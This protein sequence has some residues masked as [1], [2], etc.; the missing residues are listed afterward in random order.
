MKKLNT[1]DLDG[2]IL[3]TFL[4]ILESSSVSNAAEK[5][6]LSQSNVSH[7]L[8]KLRTILGDPL[9]VRSGQG[10]TP[11]EAALAL[12]APVRAAL[13][14]LN[15]LTDLRPFDPKS[16]KM[17][18]V[19]A[20]NDMQRDLIFPQL[21]REL[22]K[23]G[24]AAEFEF[25]PSGHPTVGMMRDAKCQLALTPMAPDG[26]D[27][28]Q[29]SLFSGK[30][31]CFYD[32]SMREPPGSWAEYC[33]ADHLRVQF[34]KGRTSI[35][36]LRNVDTSKIRDPKVSVSNFNAIPRFIKGTRLI[37]TEMEPM[38]LETLKHLD[39]A[40]LPFES[41]AVT[42]YMIWHERSNNE[43]AHI[44]LRQEILRFAEKV[45]AEIAAL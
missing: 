32:A 11:T 23:E 8:A 28:F 9:F 24:I 41:D 26:S 5:L 31:M 27:I 29:K 4:T 43:P 17:H 36:V 38:R 13:D 10:L 35:G 42:I 20:A 45:R 40:P 30:M 37:A 12:K 22:Y 39:V 33:E 15:G 14:G 34:A 2:H 16:E 21:I 19:V 7:T 18:F 25:I 44:W 6:N 3:L 1:Q